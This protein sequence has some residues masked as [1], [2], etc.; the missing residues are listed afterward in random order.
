MK[1][2]KLLPVLL[3]IAGNIF[4]QPQS[5]KY[6][7]VA[8]NSQGVAIANTTIGLMVSILEGSTN[9]TAVYSETFTTESNA[10]GVF[11]VN[12]GNGNVVSGNFSEIDWGAADYFLNIALDVSGGSN[13]TDMGTTQLL[14]VPYSLYT[15]SIY[16]HYSNDTLYIGNTYVVLT[17]GGTPPGTVTDY[18]GNIY[19]TVTIGTQTWMKESLRSL[20]YSDGTPVNDV[21]VYDDDENNAEIWGRLY[22][23]DAAMRSASSSNGNPSGVQ[24]ICP[25][26]WHLPSKAEFEQLIDYV[27]AVGG[28]WK[29]KETG[30]TYW[31]MPN[32]NT[33]ESG[34]SARGSGERSN[35]AGTYQYL[36]EH[37]DFWSATEQNSSNGYHMIL[38]SN[39]SGAPIHYTDKENGYSVRC[40]KD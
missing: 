20:H 10:A 37:A 18:D 26:G 15:G 19:E 36:K 23:W 8:R 40:V 6:Q 33:N 16:V 22:S 31:E 9:G 34:F 35:V 4:A 2:I 39:Q 14:S 30:G 13:Y 38:Y 24:G 25:Q 12:I 32:S 17:G 27:G 5:F 29:L 7:A 11:S 21:W 28:G 1:K 3:I